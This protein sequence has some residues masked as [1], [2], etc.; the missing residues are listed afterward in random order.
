MSRVYLL[1]PSAHI[2]ALLAMRLRHL[3]STRPRRSLDGELALLKFD[4]DLLGDEEALGVIVRLYSEFK[5]ANPDAAAYFLARLR[6]IV[7][8]AQDVRSALMT[9]STVLT[10]VDG[11]EWTSPDPE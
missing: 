8:D 6:A 3:I 7:P 2:G 10:F 4:D 1:A 9:A 11:P 5:A